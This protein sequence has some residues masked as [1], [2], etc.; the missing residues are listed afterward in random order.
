ML[1][2]QRN[3]NHIPKRQE[4]IQTYWRKTVWYAILTERTLHPQWTSIFPYRNK[5]QN[6]YAL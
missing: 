2:N 4:R 5:E 6:R 3:E 1:Q